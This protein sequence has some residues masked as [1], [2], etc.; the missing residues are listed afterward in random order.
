VQKA[1]PG[2]P[3]D[4][5]RRILRRGYALVRPNGSTLARGLVFIA[6][7]R[8]LS[9]QVEF[10]Q[11]A[12]LNNPDFP[13]RGV[14]KDLLLSRFVEPRLVCGGFYFVPPLAHVTEPW[15]WRI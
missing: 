4:L 10:I 2:R 7:G 6:F 13:T 12:W 8:T 1:N 5:P 3:E 9:T 15:S 14:G 11:R